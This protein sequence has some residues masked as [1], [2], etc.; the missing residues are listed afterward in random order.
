[1][2]LLQ[3]NH[4]ILRLENIFKVIQPTHHA[5]W[6][7]CHTSMVPKHL[8]GQWPHHFTWK[9]RNITSF[10]FFFCKSTMLLCSTALSDSVPTET[11]HTHINTSTERRTLWGCVKVNTFQNLR[12]YPEAAYTLDNLTHCWK[13]TERASR[14]F[15]LSSGFR[16]FRSYLCGNQVCS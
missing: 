4:G 3:M 5:H 10:L 6:P 1:M 8:Q 7:L 16:A 2:D 15:L 12:D 9:W 14:G 11:S 13:Q